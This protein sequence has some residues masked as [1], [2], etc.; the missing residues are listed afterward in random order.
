MHIALF[1]FYCATLLSVVL[2]DPSPKNATINGPSFPFFLW[3]TFLQRISPQWNYDTLKIAPSH[4]GR[5]LPWI[6]VCVLSLMSRGAALK[7]W[8]ISLYTRPVTF[9]DYRKNP[10]G[11]WGGIHAHLLRFSDLQFLSQIMEIP[12][13]W[14]VISQ[15]SLIDYHEPY[16]W[17]NRED[18]FCW[19]RISVS[20]RTE[21]TSASE[22][23]C[24]A[25]SAYSTDNDNN[26]PCVRI[27]SPS[28]E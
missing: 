7:L 23:L 14:F 17:A 28:A 11:R 13:D 25:G 22:S 2:S 10:N 27:I 12:V 8:P 24:N 15:G 18:G 16:K 26:A 6:I 4:V 21:S 19:V 5:T 3:R 9:I 1:V 20:P